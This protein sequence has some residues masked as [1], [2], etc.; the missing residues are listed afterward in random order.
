MKTSSNLQ[1]SNFNNLAS[2]IDFAFTQKMFNINTLMVCVFNQYSNNGTP[3]YGTV[4]Q[5]INN[6]DATGVPLISP[7][8]FDVPIGYIMG[9]DAGIHITYAK[10]DLVLVGYSQQSLTILKENW[11]NGTNNPTQLSPN[12]YGK[13]T[14]EDG[15]ILCKISATLPTTI[16]DIQNTGIT[17]TSNNHPVTINTGTADTTINCKDAI[18]NATT[19][20]N[21]TANNV[22]VNSSNINLGGSGGA[23]VLTSNTQIVPTALGTACT[24]TPGTTSTTT[25]AL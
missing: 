8:Q 9:G 23:Y 13:F 2:T 17:I 14:L 19:N 4:T 6:I 20:A 7:M 18:I 1:R 22:N 11:N 10:D 15:I 12:N 3:E 21:I 24:I 5:L 16:I 25:K